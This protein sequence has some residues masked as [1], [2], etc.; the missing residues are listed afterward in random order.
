MP[1][2]SRPIVPEIV[3]AAEPVVDKDDQ[4]RSL[5]DEVQRLNRELTN[6]RKAFELQAMHFAL[7]KD[8]HR[9]K[10]II[11]L[12]KPDHEADLIPKVAALEEENAK[13][14][15]QLENARAR[16]SSSRRSTTRSPAEDKR[17]ASIV[18]LDKDQLKV[19]R[20]EED[21]DGTDALFNCLAASAASRDIDTPEAAYDTMCAPV[22]EDSSY[23]MCGTINAK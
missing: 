22:V 23:T 16:A 20:V 14:K 17:R 21:V 11:T 18:K 10:S 12:D 15:R 6:A 3:Y 7:P 13:L 1:K 2:E 4:I 8:D 9:R 19:L 5:Q